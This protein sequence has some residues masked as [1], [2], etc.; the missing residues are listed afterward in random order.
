MKE[1]GAGET[2]VKDMLEGFLALN[3]WIADEE[4]KVAFEV[5]CLQL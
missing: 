2:E 4:K 5:G 3:E 1:L